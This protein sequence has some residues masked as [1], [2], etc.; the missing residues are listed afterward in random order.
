MYLVSRVTE[1][2]FA[3]KADD[4]FSSVYNR[5]IVS[6]AK[7]VAMY[8]GKTLRK[9]KLRTSSWEAKTWLNVS[10]VDFSPIV[11]RH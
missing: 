2:T 7:M 5:G 9:G 11:R 1:I 8:V 6:L 4:T 3:T 10:E